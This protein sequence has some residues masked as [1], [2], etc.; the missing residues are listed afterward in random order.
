[1]H[2]HLQRL[3]PVAAGPGPSRVLIFQGLRVRMG[4]ASGTSS[5]QEVT[6]NASLGRVK[7]G[8]ALMAAA[9]AIQDVAQGGMVLAT[10]ST[11]KQLSVESLGL[12]VISMGEHVLK[13][14][15]EAVQVYHLVHQALSYRAFHLGDVWASSG[16]WHAAQHDLNNRVDSLSYGPAGA[17][18]A[19]GGMSSA[20]AALPVA[21]TNLGSF[22]LK[23]IKVQATALS[24]SCPA[25]SQEL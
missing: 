21:A 12:L 9:K 16:A 22:K 5:A 13:A 1:M 11:F 2:E 18:Q 25:Q 10:S 14:G 20:A 3:V 6:F 23:G 8:G 7:Y 24:H 4:M 15:E 19:A 17:E